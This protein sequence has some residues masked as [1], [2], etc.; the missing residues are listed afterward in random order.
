MTTLLLS[1]HS[2]EDNQ[3][4]W[5]AAVRSG[6]NVERVRGLTLPESLTDD[7]LVLYVE[8]LFAPEIAKKLSLM[9]IGPEED[10]LVKLPWEYRK[11]EVR[12]A[13]LGEARKLKE[14]AF[15]KP[16]NEKLFTAKV[17]TS[18]SELPVDYD[19]SMAV[20]IAEPV[21]FEVEYRCFVLDRAIRTM[22]SY[23][24][25]GRLARLDDFAAPDD[26]R[27]ETAEFGRRLLAD[28]SVEVSSRSCAGPRRYQWP[29]LGSCG[30]KRSLG[31]GHL[32][33]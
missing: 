21:T 8:A 18:G 19:D 9:L 1:A 24:R 3:A 17:F 30:S 6:W 20:L 23:L 12:L 29:R 5:R 16:P 27:R 33:L 32:W 11:R 22:S 26:E 15:V 4:L 28:N 10:W 25:R 7:E 14:P 2:T 31:L 13:T